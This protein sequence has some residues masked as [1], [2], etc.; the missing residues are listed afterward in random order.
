MMAKGAIKDVA[1]ALGFSFE[2][3]NAITSLIPDQLKITL[4][5]AVEQEPRLKELIAQNPKAKRM[6]DIAFK[7]EGLTRHASKHAAGI[8]I[9]PEPVASVLPL[10]V[11]PKTTE[12]VSQYGMSE[13]EY[14]GFLKIDLLGLKNLTLIDQVIKM[15]KTLHNV[16]I[17][18]NKLPLDD[19]KTFTLLC[20]GKTSGV[21]QLES[22]GL[23]DVLR[24]LQPTKFEDVIAVNALYRPG[25]LGSGMVDD[26]VARRHG[27][28]KIAYLF[29]ELAPI[30]EET[31]GVIVYQEQVIKIASTI[32]GYSLGEA[33]ILRR[34]MGKK[35]PEEMQKQE[36]I[37]IERATKKGFDQKKA[38]ELFD[39]MAYFA[40]YGFNKSHSAAYALIAY[41]TAYLKA[42]Y[43]S[44]FMACLISLEADNAEKMA[45]YIDE[46]KNLGIT[47]LPP[48]INQSDIKFKV[49]EEKILFGLQGIKSVGLVSLENII[50]ER[51]KNGPFTDMLD[52]CK[53]IDLR[54][55]NKRVLENLVFAGACDRLPGNRAQKY[56]ELTLIIEKAIAYKKDAATGQM[57]LFQ[58]VQHTQ[59]DEK[60]PHIFEHREEWSN[61]E[62]LTKEKETI[63]FY[64]SAHPLDTYQ[65][66]AQSFSLNNFEDIVKGTHTY[67]NNTA[68][69]CGSLKSK[70]II[71]TKKGE[72][73]CF[74]QL[75]DKTGNAEIIIFPKLFNKVEPFLDCY[76]VF[77]IKG[78]IDYSSLQQCKI[79]ATVCVPFELL[80]TE[81]PKIE[82]ITATFH[83]TFEEN[84]VLWLKETLPN[85]SI[86]F[87][88]VIKEN[89]QL[90][91][92]IARKKISLNFDLLA[93]WNEKNIVAIKCLL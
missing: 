79:K 64:V 3:S 1:R 20:D 4:T 77:I 17:N 18:I 26:F 59:F 41:Q 45:F 80:W 34:A 8:V 93:Q 48:D 89:N 39:L 47:I 75:E 33:D 14:I 66:Y 7:L 49:V 76:Q 35:K 84:S 72:R 11:P 90:V 28:Q 81:W 92:V 16:S 42:H 52:F 50:A 67:Q 21:F 43:K 56:E 71:T 27:R 44:I 68:L 9:S 19:E 10:Y 58:P 15:I 73:M 46:A 40:G 22:E 32:G 30:L 12:L 82:K 54:S 86:P 65:K 70:R 63:G 31:Y 57:G 23:K 83:T 53:R 88:L 13:L 87:E 74:L 91:K 24:K 2:D 62:K 55:A 78:D 69:V 5:E 36:S 61:K 51:I 25:P 85:G 37:F 6:F 38:K 60:Q 29:Q